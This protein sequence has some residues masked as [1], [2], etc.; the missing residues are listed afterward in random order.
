MADYD[1]LIV[2]AGISGIGVARYLTKELPG[3]SYA[4]LEGRENLGGTWDLFRYPGIRSDSDCHTMGF[5]FKPWTDRKAISEAPAILAY[6]REAVGENGIAPHILYRHKVS[7]ARSDTDAA[8]WTVPL[9][10]GRELT[11][12][13]LVSGTGYYDYD[14]PFV[15]EIE[16]VED[17]AGPI[18]HPQ[19][20]P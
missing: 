9:Q 17:F 16:G 1:V 11:S 18:F 19:R 12:R 7:G 15:P 5:A 20:W 14:N 4:I 13:F 10:D 6:L 3:K 2:G 8:Q